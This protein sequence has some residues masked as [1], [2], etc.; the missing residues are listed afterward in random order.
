LIEDPGGISIVLVLSVL[1]IAALAVAVASFFVAGTQWLLVVSAGL[2]VLAFY[3]SRRASR[4]VPDPDGE[5]SAAPVRGRVSASIDQLGLDESG[6]DHD[7]A[8][9]DRVEES[10]RQPE[11]GRA[12]AS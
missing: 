2:V 9:S 11:A 7:S 3:V 5:H 10:D 4:G 1:I 6:R 12:I 8:D